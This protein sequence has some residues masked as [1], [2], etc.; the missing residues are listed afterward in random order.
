[1]NS[2][3]FQAFSFTA[4]PEERP[5]TY[6]TH[7]QNGVY[8]ADVDAARV[9]VQPRR[10][11]ALKLVA[12]GLVLILTAAAVLGLLARN[13][14]LESALRAAQ[15]PSSLKQTAARADVVLSQGEASAQLLR[16]SP[17]QGPFM[18]VANA[19]TRSSDEEHKA[20]TVMDIAKLGKPSVVAITTEQTMT[21]SGFGFYPQSYSVPVAGS[22]F[23]IDEKGYIATNNHVIENSRNIMVHTEDGGTY[24]AT[25]VGADQQ[26]DLAVIKIE[27]KDSEKFAAVKFGDSDALV[28]GELAVAIGNPSGTLEG[29]VTAGIISALQRTITVQGLEMTVL[30]TDAAI[31][32]GNS[33]GALFNSYGEVIGINTA[34]LS[35]DGRTTFDG[36]AFAIPSNYAVG[37]LKDLAANGKVTTR[38]QLGIMGVGVDSTSARYYRLADRPGVLIQE[39]MKGGSADKA[40]LKSGDFIV[41]IDGNPV[42]SISTINNLKREWKIGDKVEVVYFRNGESTTTEMTLQGL[43]EKAEAEFK[44]EL[45]EQQNDQDDQQDQ[46]SDKRDNA[47]DSQSDTWDSAA[48]EAPGQG[49][50]R[51]YSERDLPNL[52]QD[53]LDQLTRP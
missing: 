43:D 25:V 35:S 23:F 47:Q 15:L 38:V 22:G 46:N 5:V 28:V 29:S 44:K 10:H 3:R 32:S 12:L 48:P 53:F 42:D 41:E 24:E 13:R 17:E 30:Q 36:I 16:E 37:V 31:N 34:K 51:T 7:Q 26:S 18:S 21:T 49:K 1:M 50:P 39:I 9:A 11:S 8:Y 27:P 33:G 4:R 19:A 45:A 52:F 2:E 20:L 14:R 6:M 40:G